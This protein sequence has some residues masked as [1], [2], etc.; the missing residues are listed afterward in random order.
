MKKILYISLNEINGFGGGAISQK[1]I[2]DGVIQFI[3]KRNNDILFEVISL[4][5]RIEYKSKINVKKNRNIDM[6]S[7]VYG[8]SSYFYI[9]WRKFRNKFDEVNPD[10]LILGTSRLGF[11][12]KRF[13]KLNPKVEIIT[14]FENIEYDYVDAYFCNIDSLKGKLMKIIERIFVKRD[15]YEAIKYSDRLIFLTNRD[16][17]RAHEC[18]K[19]TDKHEVIL[20]I[21]IEGTVELKSI[22]D[23]THNIVFLGSLDYGSN[24]D[25]LM[26]FLNEV[27]N[28]EYK[29]DL[30]KV[31]IVGGCNA[32]EELINTI[33][34]Y[35]NVILHNNFERKE[36]IIP[37]GSL[38]IAPIRTG[39]GMKVKIA[40]A[41]S[42][43]LSVVASDEALIG[44]ED[45]IGK[46]TS[47]LGV[48]RANTKS[49]YKK[50][51]DE[52]FEKSST[53]LNQI[54]N[55]NIEAFDKYYSY[56]RSR[57]TIVNEINEII[58]KECI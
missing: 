35:K 5:E 29:D 51:I 11:V 54:E 55:Y 43:G 6:L 22:N 34:E 40:E 58:K 18:Y 45:I 31:L 44:Y 37:I 46:E 2:Y 48:Y 17:K 49:E 57:E 3:K 13:K 33:N 21:C 15:E 42:M 28:K 9:N 53:E 23:T 20:P 12:A 38:F 32:S 50:Y 25:A 14:N 52:Y 27:W 7:R 24:L 4:D 36:D 19:Y 47:K 41:L 1:R 8:H 16:K 30:R 56:K 39:A 10:I 26:W